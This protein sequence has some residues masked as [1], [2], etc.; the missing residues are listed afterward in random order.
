MG[1]GY[2]VLVLAGGRGQAGAGGTLVL[3]L[4][5]VPLLPP[6]PQWT[7][8]Q[9]ENVTFPRTSYAGGNNHRSFQDI[10][11]HFLTCS[12]I[13]YR[14]RKIHLTS[15]VKRFDLDLFQCIVATVGKGGFNTEDP[16]DKVT[17][18][19]YKALEYTNPQ[20]G[21][22]TYIQQIEQK[23]QEKHS[24]KHMENFT[25]LTLSNTFQL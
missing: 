2:P 12:Y 9:S 25:N 11:C 24:K 10:K 5:G 21:I 15:K 7:D 22:N 1:W 18:D 3:V 16:F 4:A 6:L 20:S 19:T 23:K 14:L 8:K 13:H 17:F